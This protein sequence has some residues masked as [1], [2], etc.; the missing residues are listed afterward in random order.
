MRPSLLVASLWLAAAPANAQGAPP[1]DVPATTLETLTV[2]PEPEE[3]VDLYRFRNP[4]DVQPGAFGRH[5]KE[6]TSLEQ[7]GRNGGIVPV[8]AGL[9]AK[10]IQ[11]GARKLPGWKEPMQS[12]TARPPPLDDGQAARA[13]RLHDAGEQP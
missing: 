8:L 13:L 10:G 7:L 5:W 6:P 2:R 4:V 11:T 9:A 12:V 1:P 3:V